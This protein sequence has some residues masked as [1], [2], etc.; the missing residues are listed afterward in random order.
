MEVQQEELSQQVVVE[1]D[2]GVRW[3]EEVE[4]GEKMEAEVEVVKLA[5]VES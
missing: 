4:V 5:M 1:K 3:V 2:V